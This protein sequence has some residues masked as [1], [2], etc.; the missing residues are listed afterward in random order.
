M[1]DNRMHRSTPVA[2]HVW[3]FKVFCAGLLSYRSE[4]KRNSVAI[5]AC[6]MSGASV[7][8]SVPKNVGGYSVQIVEILCT[9][10]EYLDVLLLTMNFE[11]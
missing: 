1:P 2:V 8:I 4:R 3:H 10:F 5:I 9:I 7:S 11:Q 6:K